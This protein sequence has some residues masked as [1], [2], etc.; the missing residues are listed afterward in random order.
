MIMMKF[1]KHLILLAVTLFT[2]QFSFAQMQEL[3]KEIDQIV[4]GKN[5]TLGLAL[6]DFRTGETL[7][8]NGDKRFPM[9]SVYKFQIGLALLDRV[10]RALCSLSDSVV[11]EKKDLSPDLWS[12]IRESYPDGVTLPLSEVITYAVAQSD[13]SASDLLL[14]MAGGP[15]RVQRF[16]HSKGVRQMRIANSEKE[17]QGSWD[18]QFKN[19]AT[20]D[21]MLQLLKLFNQEK[22]LKAETQNFM[23]DVMTQ[24]QTG[25]LRQLLPSELVVA[26]KTGH[27][28][29]GKKG[30]VAANNDVGIM[31]L[32]DGRRVAFVIFLANSRESS[33]MNYKIIAQISSAVYHHFM[34]LATIE[35]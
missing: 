10:D 29:V 12:P 13:N 2:A 14:A 33:E 6:H 25:S 26:H 21:A 20:P 1:H 35:K 23:W 9:Q 34:R 15:Q 22:L 5:L 27:S 32:P 18:V 24:T 11:I 8:V 30:V 19:W 31:V 16:V 7:S 17:I 28:G 4:A 3:Q